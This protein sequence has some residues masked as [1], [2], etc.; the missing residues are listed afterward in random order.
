TYEY[1][2]TDRKAPSTL[3]EHPPFPLG[4]FHAA[5]IQYVFQT[6]FPAGRVSGPPNFSPPQI[7]ISNQMAAYWSN[8]IKTG[9]PDGASPRWSRGKPDQM[10]ILSLSPDGSR[11]ESDFLK[12]HHCALWNSVRP[13]P[14]L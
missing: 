1:E 2:F 7:A 13:E 14:E 10:K 9:N 4:A 8:F 6:Y 5:E 3:I 12:A 11:Y